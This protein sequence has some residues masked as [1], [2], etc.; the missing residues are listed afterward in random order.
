VDSNLAGVCGGVEVGQQWWPRG[1]VEGGGPRGAGGCAAAIGRR[2]SGG[3]PRVA[4]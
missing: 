4:G 2:W 1:W 3:G